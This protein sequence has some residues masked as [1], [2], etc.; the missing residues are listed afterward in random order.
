MMKHAILLVTLIVL[1]C[2]SCTDIKQRK[3][4]CDELLEVRLYQLMFHKFELN[5]LLENIAQSKGISKKDLLVENP[6]SNTFVISWQAGDRSYILDVQES[7]PV[8]LSVFDNTNQTIG[9]ALTCLGIPDGY[10]ATTSFT[11]EG[12]TII[13]MNL[14]YPFS[15]VQFFQSDPWI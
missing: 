4:N 13:E 8:S 6:K 2:L 5:D 14:F 7:I 12:I 3:P 1:T 15:T 9:Q 10:L 11:A